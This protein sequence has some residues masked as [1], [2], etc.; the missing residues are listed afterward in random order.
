[1]IAML[2][3]TVPLLAH[4]GN[5]EAAAENE[6]R[7][8]EWKIKPDK[9]GV[10][11]VSA[12]AEGKSIN[13]LKLEKPGITQPRYAIRGE[14]SY[15]DVKGMGFLEMWNYFDDGGFYFTRTLGDYGPMGALKGDSDWRPFVMPFNAGKGQVPNRLEV[16][17]VLP[18]GGTVRLRGAV[19]V[20]YTAPATTTT[21]AAVIPAVL[22][23]K[24]QARPWWGPRAGGWFGSIFGTVIGICG[25]IIGTL[26]GRG[27]ARR[28]VMSL[29][30]TL[31]IVGGGLFIAGLVAV[32]LRQP[33]S[34]WYPL[35][36][37][38]GL[39]GGL[40]G[41]LLPSLKRRYEQAEIRKMQA[42]DAMA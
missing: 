36:L 15:T 41:G 23:D 38:G 42:L 19:L 11:E 30:I 31:M 1:M 5:A 10:I 28:F 16:N 27:R 3:L 34:V 21:K 20:E 24:T 22:I 14:V 17:V 7:K 40:I 39:S 26:A 37:S 9:D 4:A 33:Y 2:A 6:V 12:P 13:I 18:K 25:G 29:A 32:M 35:L 8:I